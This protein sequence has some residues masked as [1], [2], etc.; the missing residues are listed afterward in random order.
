MPPPRDASTTHFS[1]PYLPTS[2]RLDRPPDPT[3]SPN[4]CPFD[5]PDS[6]TCRRPASRHPCFP[7]GLANPGF[8]WTVEEGESGAKRR[9]PLPQSPSGK[10]R[11]HRK[12][13]RRLVALKEETHR[14]KQ[15]EGNTWRETGRDSRR[16]PA[17]SCY[18]ADAS[19]SESSAA[20][21]RPAGHVI[22]SSPLRS[23]S[24]RTLTS[25]IAITRADSSYSTLW[26]S[27]LA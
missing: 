21:T 5:V 12:A 7:P 10:P 24:Q 4:P 25:V 1:P 23:S 22:V 17:C 2:D 8:T 9:T 20:L 14:T 3:H 11:K 27:G 16:P 19:T 13:G 18:A 6:T 26:P 15:M